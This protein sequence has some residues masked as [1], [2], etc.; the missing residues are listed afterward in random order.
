MP[1]VD[2]F[3]F[4]KVISQSNERFVITSMAF[5]DMQKVNKYQFHEKN[6][7]TLA[8]EIGKIYLAPKWFKSIPLSKL[9]LDFG[10]LLWRRR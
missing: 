1:M 8:F 5:Y 2:L 10:H 7:S 4:T 3:L 9:L 6:V